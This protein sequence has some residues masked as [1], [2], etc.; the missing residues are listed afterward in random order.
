MFAHQYRLT[1]LSA[2][3]TLMMFLAGSGTSHALFAGQFGGYYPWSG[4][5]SGYN[6]F[7]HSNSA[8]FSAVERRLR[9]LESV[10]DRLAA[11]ECQSG[12]VDVIF[13][14]DFPADESDPALDCVI[15]LDG[16][17]DVV[18][19]IPF[20]PIFEDD[21]V[22]SLGMTGLTLLLGKNCTVNVE[23]ATPTSFDLHVSV[24]EI[25]PLT[26]SVTYMA[27]PAAIRPVDPRPFF[28]LAAV[29]GQLGNGAA[30]EDGVPGV[31]VRRSKMNQ[32][33]LK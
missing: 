1:K 6:G 2:L 17:E 30:V 28:P 23:N 31:A 14:E 8:S 20:D 22:V 33:S 29:K 3:A 25:Q 26:M 18:L 15:L 16:R 32:L 4:Y 10:V 11:H 5:P 21:P 19:T 24:D 7:Q 12:V 13:C 9:E 27:C